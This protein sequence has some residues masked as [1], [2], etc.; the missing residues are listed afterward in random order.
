[1]PSDG[2]EDLFAQF[3]S[4]VPGADVFASEGTSTEATTVAF[5]L[6]LRAVIEDFERSITQ[7]RQ[8]GTRWAS[9]NTARLYAGDAITTLQITGYTLDREIKDAT[10]MFHVAD[11]MRAVAAEFRHIYKPGTIGRKYSGLRHFFRYLSQRQLSIPIELGLKTPTYTLK[12]PTIIS[13][14]QFA[15]FITEVLMNKKFGN[16]DVAIYSL[17]FHDGFSTPGIASLSYDD[18]KRDEGQ[19]THVMDRHG[20]R[21]RERLIN[22]RTSDFM[23]DYER[24]FEESAG[25]GIDVPLNG[26]TSYFRS[27]DNR[28]L[29]DRSIR[30]NYTRDAIRNGISPDIAVLRRTYLF[31]QVSTKPLDQV[32]EEDGL[33]INYLRTFKQM[34]E[35]D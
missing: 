14:D 3:A 17:M 23:R 33:E 13:Q 22:E 18:I 2:L 35:I 27:K 21:E 24:W 29:T 20:P 6:T 28:R 19:I 9:P 16:R 34:M 12:D 31:N 30:R 10:E 4:G 5:P 8:D 7:G 32:V 15:S 1:M 26:E 25:M 11:Q